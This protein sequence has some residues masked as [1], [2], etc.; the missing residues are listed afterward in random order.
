MST[1]PVAIEN[2]EPV[3]PEVVGGQIL[4]MNADLCTRGGRHGVTIRGASDIR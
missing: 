1:S 3:L 2:C 4:S